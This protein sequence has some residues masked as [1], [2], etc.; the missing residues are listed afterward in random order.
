MGAAGGRDAPPPPGGGRGRTALVTGSQGFIGSYVCAELLGRGYS[1][2]GVDDYS[3]YGPLARPHDSHPSFRLI[4]ADCAGEAFRRSLVE[5]GEA[6]TAFDYIVAGAAMIGGISYF[7]RRAYDLLA[8]NERILANTFDVAIDRHRRG[9]LGRIVVVSSSMAYE[10]ATVWPTPEGHQL[11]CP[12]P[13]STYGFQKLASEY[14]ARGASEQYGLPYTIV[15][16]FNCVGVGEDAALGEDEVMSGNVRLLMSHVVPDLVNKCLLGQDPL[17][18]LGSGGQVRHYTNGRDVARGIRMAME[19]PGAAG[20]DFNISTGTGT[21]VA[22]LA[23]MV[24]ERINPG[25]PLRTASDPPYEHDVQRRAPDVEK[26]RRVLG[27]EAEIGLG[28]SLDEVISWMRGR[29]SAA[30]RGAGGGAGPAARAQKG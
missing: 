26:A 4:R 28:E 1:V 17:R 9:M 14:F 23:R 13:S 6:G 24:W 8:A 18:I 21:T 29:K 3:K 19:S 2:V 16:P 20:E 22:E 5:G 25:R 11:E 10:N 30:A 15:R 7:H 27:F 12:A